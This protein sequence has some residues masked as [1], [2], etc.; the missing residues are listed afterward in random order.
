MKGKRKEIG[1]RE[2]K[3]ERWCVHPR[4]GGGG[5]GDARPQGARDRD[6]L[7]GKWSGAWGTGEHPR[8]AMIGR[9][10]RVGKVQHMGWT[11]DAGRKGKRGRFEDIVLLLPDG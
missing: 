2:K 8:Q 5:E 3:R 11:D 4:A 6:R 1:Q 7:F 9:V 10:K